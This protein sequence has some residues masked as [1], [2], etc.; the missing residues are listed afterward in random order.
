QTAY[1]GNKGLKIVA[2]H[3]IN[4]PDRNTGNRPYPDAL[5]STW[6]NNSD[7]SYYHAW[8]STLRTRTAHGLSFNVNYTWGR[9]MAI[10]EG[11]F[12][13]GKNARVQDEDNWR[14][15][16]GPATYDI[17][18]RF[19]ADWVY[20]LPYAGA[21]VWKRITEG[22]QLSGSLFAQSGNRLDIVERSNYDSSRPDY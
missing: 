8:Q 9:A 20:R 18:H 16:K 3:N 5:Q 15:N 1:V 13:S 2:Q 14:A 17:T 6:N 12:Y 21:G 4:L 11:D 10:N 22:W 19:V 7:F